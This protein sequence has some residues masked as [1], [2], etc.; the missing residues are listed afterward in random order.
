MTLT[1]RLGRP[2]WS[3]QE[4][5]GQLADERNRLDGLR[6]RDLEVRASFSLSYGGLQTEEQRLF[7]LLGLLEAP[8]MARWTAAAL[9]DTSPQRAEDLLEALADARL[10]DVADPT[11]PVSAATAATTSSASTLANSPRL[12]TAKRIAPPR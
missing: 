11:K 5:A 7:R 1:A 8:D 9:L 3:V 10:L 4:L 12:P 2:H 6:H